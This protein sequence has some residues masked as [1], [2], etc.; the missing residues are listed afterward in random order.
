M[1]SAEFA[2]LFRS[3]VGFDRLFDLLDNSVRTDWPP[4]NIEKVSDDNYRIA[5]AVAGFGPEEVDLIQHG[6]EL[7]VTGQKKADEDGPEFLHRGLANRSFKQVF[8]L[9]DHVKVAKASLQNGLLTVGLTREIPEEM[10]PRRIEIAST[11]TSAEIGTTGEAEQI[12]RTGD[13]RRKAA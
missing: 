5:M 11:P 9:A 1:R 6:A 10:K 4:Y 13:G 8:R 3:T 2:P 12:G 7:I